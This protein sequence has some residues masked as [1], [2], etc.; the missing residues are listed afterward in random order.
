MF[1]SSPCLVALLLAATGVEAG[2]RLW[3]PPIKHAKAAV[4]A[5]ITVRDLSGVNNIYSNVTNVSSPQ[6]GH[7]KRYFGL[8][9]PSDSPDYPHLWPGGNINACYDTA[10]FT[11]N[12]ETG[13]TVRDIL[14]TDLLAAREL[15]RLN[16][17]DDKGDTF[18][19]NIL[20]DGDP[21]C[22][23]ALRSTHL[24][25]LYAGEGV[26][27]MATSVGMTRPA[28]AP[29]PDADTLVLGPTMTLTDILDIGMG[30]PV[31][32]YAHEMGVSGLPPRASASSSNLV[33]IARLGYA[34]R[35]PESQVVDHAI[36]RC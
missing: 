31:A 1:L 6:H 12:G 26:R 32:N 10:T 19:F 24:L 22:A 33:T 2:S 5:A 7:Q 27:K 11:H 4:A 23:Q 13:K 29:G 28:G 8:N 36:R 25:I 21:G 15:W 20:P 14:H 16:G 18:K 9:T 30:N 35:A 17:L 34:P 3:Q